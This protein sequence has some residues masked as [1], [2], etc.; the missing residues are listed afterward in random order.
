M[1]F[2][3]FVIIVNLFLNTFINGLT[4]DQK[5]GQLFIVPVCPWRDEDHQKDLERALKEFFVGGFILKQ[6]DIDSQK[7]LIKNL[8]SHSAIPLLFVMDAEWGL[9][10]TLSDAV[11]FPKNLTLGAIQNE[12]RLFQLGEEIG[13]ECRAVGA[14]MNLAPVLDIN[15]NPN[16]PIIGMRSFGED[17]AAV[18]K[19]GLLMMQGMHKGGVLTCAKHFPGHGDTA[20]DSHKELPSIMCSLNALKER[21]LIPFQ[22]CIQEGIPA[23]MTGHLHVPALD[24][25]F[26][27]TL[28]RK[29]IDDFLKKQLH[30][31]GLVITDALN[32]KAL[33]ATYSV[34]EIAVMAYLAGNDLLLYGDHIA[35]TVD[36]IL[37][38]DLP[39]AFR[40]LKRACQE[41]I[42]QEEELTQRV[43]KIMRMKEKIGSP[44]FEEISWELA[45]DLKRTLYR[46]AMTLLKNE[47]ELIP[48]KENKIGFVAFGD[49]RILEKSL[50]EKCSIFEESSLFVVAVADAVPEARE[51]VV[52]LVKDNR[53]VILIFLTTPYALAS[54]PPTEAVMMAYENDEE[55]QRAASDLLFGRLYPTGKLPVTVSS[56]F[57]CGVGLKL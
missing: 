9:S 35:D 27:A 53:R 2:T 10:M 32:M 21:E 42:I 48:L 56:D 4:L 6:G 26:P 30:F 45:R 57:P 44:S 34:E 37:R 14:Q 28:S 13:K 25:K 12:Q 50:R 7:A 36:R 18:L 38:D 40:A 22:G 1:F 29:V 52:E 24:E 55:A 20:Q 47:N 16:N 17:S 8:L 5:I 54:F 33:T 46:E 31:E 3:L 39:Q 23:I 51:K 49:A 11:Q 15:A 19:K 43:E 41:G